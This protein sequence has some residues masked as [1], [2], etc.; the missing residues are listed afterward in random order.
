M[1]NT[2]YTFSPAFIPGQ[3]VRS[4]EVNQ[5]YSAIESA[6]DL[7][8]TDNSA[9]LRGTT[10]L[11]VESGTP[12]ALEV[13][14]PDPR[15]SYQ[16]GDKIQFKA[17]NNNTGPAT[18][19]IDTL[20]AVA[21]VSAGG[22]PISPDDIET[23]IYYEAIFDLANN[24]WQLTG[25]GT[26]VVAQAQ[27]RVDWAEEWAINPEDDP[28]SVAA[29]GDDSTTFSA[30]HWA[31][32][33]NTSALAAISSAGAADTSATDADNSAIAAA[34]SAAGVNLPPV[35]IANAG[36]LLKVNAGGTGY[37][38]YD[39]FGSS[40]VWTGNQQLNGSVL[41]LRNDSVAITQTFLQFA[42]L[43][44]QGGATRW[45][46]QIKSGTRD[47][48]MYNSAN[49]QKFQIAT[50]ALPLETTSTQLFFG[51]VDVQRAATLTTT[52]LVERATQAEVDAG[53][54]TTRYV[55]PDT[56]HDKAAL[57]IN[58]Q[59]F[60]A[61]EI[62][63]G[64]SGSTPSIDWTSGNKQ[65]S[66]M[67]FATT[68]YSFTAPSGPTNL[69]LKL[70]QDVGGGNT[71]AWPANVNWPGGTVP[72]PTQKGGSTVDIYAFYY[73]GTEYWGSYMLENY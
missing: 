4:D 53:T 10:Y 66:T 20:G 59:A 5:Q 50:D 22:L 47:F 31:T 37:D 6:F 63:N 9:I 8:P 15:T 62:N 19:D 64:N 23:G 7:M 73:D 54:D 25:A 46:M 56:L 1:A 39:L 2:Y 40:N 34:A 58:S 14:L 12:N 18:I 30:L 70:I 60:Y 28:V 41:Q 51:G 67:T 68:T 49:I 11:G 61:S 27:E 33:A 13:T 26:A 45:S 69:I 44:A 42:D 35:T 21:L 65:K 32:K 57:K 36:E 16:D 3:K 38:V 29:G 48:A 71:A 52:G 17:T 55:T 43:I 72:A 24:R